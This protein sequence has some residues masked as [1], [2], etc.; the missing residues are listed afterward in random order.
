[1]A[2]DQNIQ[3]FL[4]QKL[5]ENKLE[6]KNFAEKSGISLTAVNQLIN[7]QRL[8]PD[9]STILKIAKYFNCTADEVIKREKYY[10][11]TKNYKFNDISLEEALLNLKNFINTKLEENK[12]KPDEL[13]QKLGFSA[14]TIVGF[15]TNK[16]KS[17]RTTVMIA[18]VDLYEVSFDEAIGRLPSSQTKNN[19]L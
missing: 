10:S 1:M 8:N 11:K 15:I 5:K 7:A 17:F 6:R 14:F 2:L 3:I 4:Q 13:A 18:L 16:N 19:K 12:L 9:I